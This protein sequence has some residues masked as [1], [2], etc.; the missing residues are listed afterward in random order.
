MSDDSDD[1]KNL[2]EV[3]NPSRLSGSK[4]FIRNFEIIYRDINPFKGNLISKFH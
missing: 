2:D 3:F 1:I 4:V